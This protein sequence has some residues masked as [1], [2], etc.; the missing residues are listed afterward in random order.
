[1]RHLL[2]IVTSLALCLA[3]A[4][5]LRA[6]VQQG[7]LIAHTQPGHTFTLA[8]ENLNTKSWQLTLRRDG[9]S[10]EP[11]LP[12]TLDAKQITFMVPTSVAPNAYLVY[13]KPNDGD[14]IYVGTIDV[15]APPKE[16]TTPRINSVVP[17]AGWAKLWWVPSRFDFDI[18]GDRLKVSKD[19]TL[20]FGAQRLVL[21]RCATSEQH[22]YNFDDQKDPCFES[23]SD[24][25]LGVH[26]IPTN[27]YRGPQKLAIV[28]DTGRS[29]DDV[30]IRISRITPRMIKWLSFLFLL[31]IVGGLVSLGRDGFS[32]AAGSLRQRFL[33]WVLLDP[34]TN[35]FSLSK[36]QFLMWMFT[37]AYCYLFL[38]L[39]FVFAQGNLTLAPLPA[40]FGWLIGVTGGTALTSIALTRSRGSKGAGDVGPRL[41]DLVST[42]GV[43]APD[44]AQLLLWTVIG[45]GAYIL[46]VLRTSTES[47]H[48]L[49]TVPE[50]LLAAMGIS[51][52]VYAGGKS[53]RLPGPVI[54]QITA[55]VAN[56]TLTVK[57]QN[58]HLNALITLDQQPAEVTITGTPMPNAA[59]DKLSAELK[60]A[61]TALPP[62][63]EDHALRI[64]NLDGQY[65]EAWF[66]VT[67]PV[68]NSIAVAGGAAAD[69]V[70]LGSAPTTLTLTGTNFRIGSSAEWL[71]TGQT[72]PTAIPATDV[73][74]TKGVAPAPDTATVTV[75]PGTTKGGATLTLLSPHSIR[76]SRR[77]SVQ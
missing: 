60:L 57:G 32:A 62:D 72:A 15:D 45:C 38:Q 51:A 65:A 36:V 39:A 53:V 8:G 58:L 76:A 18:Y 35:T 69:V 1:M 43:L 67:P 41:S 28:A 31:A 44:R 66:A 73:V 11:I 47:L 54:N 10:S 68:I 9:A 77:V 12:S 71:P 26:G 48:V 56:N 61:L 42:G 14:A 20:F 59:S 25:R 63:N 49:P 21:K 75:K 74:V 70:P 37:I 16:E 27:E 40:N 4:S 19:L 22:T 55:D 24:Q 3:C 7:Q 34:Q 50:D 29:N 52:A 5:E 13:I 46:I 64:T 33:S 23:T 2:T 6:Q 30:T 17:T